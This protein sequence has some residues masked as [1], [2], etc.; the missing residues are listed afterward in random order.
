MFSNG[1]TNNRQEDNDDVMSSLM[2][3]LG[4][5][6][7]YTTTSSISQQ[8][9][10]QSASISSYRRLLPEI[11]G[12]PDASQHHIV[13]DTE[14]WNP[15]VASAGHHKSSSNRTCLLPTNPQVEVIRRRTYEKFKQSC[16][17]TLQEESTKQQSKSRNGSTPNPNLLP[18][19]CLPSSSVPAF[20]EKWHMDCKLNEYMYL[21]R[22][23][24]KKEKRKQQKVASPLM[25][26]NRHHPPRVIDTTVEI[27]RQHQTIQKQ[28]SSKEGL[29]SSIWMDPIILSKRVVSETF[30]KTY[31]EEILES[32]RKKGIKQ[33]SADSDDD[34]ND[35]MKRHNQKLSKRVKSVSKAIYKFT[36]ESIEQ[37]TKELSNAASREVTQLNSTSLFSSRKKGKKKK[38]HNK[39]PKITLPIPSSYGDIISAKVGGGYGSDGDRG[40]ERDTDNGLVTVTYVGLSFQIHVKHY[41]KLQRL[42]DRSTI[43]SSCDT[44]QQHQQHSV[45]DS[46]SF[47]DALFCLL[48]RYDT[49]Q[50]A[51]LQASVPGYVMDVLLQKFHCDIECFASPFNCRYESFH[52]IF[53]DV[54]DIDSLFGSVGNL[55]GRTI[56][57]NDLSVASSSPNHISNKSSDD[58]DSNDDS[59]SSAA[60]ENSRRGCCYEANP[61]FCER[62]ISE[63]CSKI[64]TVIPSKQGASSSVTHRQQRAQI[65][66][67]LMFVVIVPVWSESRA[68]Q[69]LVKLL[70]DLHGSDDDDG[71]GDGYDL[72]NQGSNPH[73]VILPQ[74]RHWYAEGTQYR[75]SKTF[76]VASFDTSIFL[77]QNDIAQRRW[78][79][80]RDTLDDLKAAFMTDPR[81]ATVASSSTADVTPTLVKHEKAQ[82]TSTSNGKHIGGK[83][84]AASTCAIRTQ[85]QKRDKKKRNAT[86]TD[87]PYNSDSNVSCM[88]SKNKKRKESIGKTSTNKEGR[89]KKKRKH[90][91]NAQAEAKAQLDLLKSL[92]LGSSNK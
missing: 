10:T 20:L 69:Q 2:Q 28:V 39:H 30:A 78:P 27:Y 76:R 77:Y 67:P 6:Q 59:G 45:V 48:C 52:S 75:R 3:E 74:S 81:K 79:L 80:T 32:W 92:G 41:E 25:S 54:G 60:V 18:P 83:P 29:S 17:Q 5:A 31:R 84:T 91:K 43:R 22:A 63:L 89:S 40:N 24:E 19:L 15:Y 12:Y 7:G 14:I 44:L 70:H 58:S 21:Q 13:G 85:R 90:A 50:G 34:I 47:E 46:Y 56:S 26:L 49:L 64:R 51:G 62:V 73:H 16:Y 86:R 9:Q 36:C 4:E 65:N 71:G 82:K 11:D 88:K 23:K 37:F 72:N 53:G 55:F 8:Q 38:N 1:S 35:V 33:A 87:P 61:P 66:Y 68:Y 42:F 57:S